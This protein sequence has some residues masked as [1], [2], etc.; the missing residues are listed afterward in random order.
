M[1]YSISEFTTFPNFL[2]L[3]L[4][5]QEPNLSHERSTQS[6]VAFFS[7]PDFYF[8]FK[9]GEGVLF[10]HVI[11]KYLPYSASQK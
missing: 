9:A 7:F 10:F 1:F 2:S 4:S 5:P 6:T 11:G 3:Y 8:P